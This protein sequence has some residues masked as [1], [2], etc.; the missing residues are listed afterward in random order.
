VSPS[1]PLTDF[2]PLDMPS[3][4]GQHDHTPDEAKRLAVMLHQIGDE[5]D[6]YTER[7]DEKRGAGNLGDV[8]VQ[9]SKLHLI[10]DNLH[11]YLHGDGDMDVL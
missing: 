11:D 5:L 1:L 7:E 6:A 3:T 2:L 9:A 10:A 4:N 8:K